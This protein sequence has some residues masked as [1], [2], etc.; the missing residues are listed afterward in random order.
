MFKGLTNLGCPNCHHPSYITQLLVQWASSGM[1]CS[2]ILWFLRREISVNARYSPATVDGTPTSCNWTRDALL[3]EVFH[4]RK[5][6][7]I[8]FSTAFIYRSYRKRKT[9]DILVSEEQVFKTFLRVQSDQDL[10]KYR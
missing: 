8:N 7:H 1:S 9:L 5:Y 3:R 4:A 6:E 10:E 2:P